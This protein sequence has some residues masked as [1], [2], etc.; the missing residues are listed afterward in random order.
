MLKAILLSALLVS[1][2]LAGEAPRVAVFPLA[3]SAPQEQRDKAGFSL[4]SKLDRLGLFEVIDGPKM[5]EMTADAGVSPDLAMP[6]GQM[7]YLAAKANAQVLL[8]GEFSGSSLKVNLLD[9]RD[10]NSSPRL[11]EKTL[12]RPTDLRFAAE[13]IVEQ[14]K[15][16]AR[17]E[18]PVETSTWDDPASD[19]AWTNNPN[20]LANGDFEKAGGW[21]G[22]YQSQLY[23][24][25]LADQEP[26]EDSVA[27]VPN[28]GGSAGNNAIE[29]KLSLQ[30]AQTNGLAALSDLV[31]ILPQTRYRLQFRYKS[32]GPVLHVFVKG[33]TKY[34]GPGGKMADREIYRR[35]VP[36]QGAT[37]GKWITVTD[38]LNPQHVSLPVQTLRVDLYAYQRPGTVLFDDVVLKA[39]GAQTR[40]ARDPAIKPLTTQP[41]R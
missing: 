9:L 4:R 37:S 18:H 31:S 19:G 12:A 5:Q 3:G 38:D 39:V 40:Q 26:G 17:F 1:S 29:L 10:A 35:Q 2:V 32:D 30:G 28:A 33:Y 6:E 20:L 23:S 25:T 41:S 34:P 15:G 16:A 27:I 7:R 36:P 22:I 24:V 13:E 8:W 11:I 14:V 21:T